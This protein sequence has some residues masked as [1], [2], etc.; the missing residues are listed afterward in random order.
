MVTI[1]AGAFAGGLVSLTMSLLAAPAWAVAGVAI[2]A[3][4]IVWMRPE[5]W[6]LFRNVH[7]GPQSKAADDEGGQ[8]EYRAITPIGKAVGHRR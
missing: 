8:Q 2:L 4:L 7:R 3:V 1:A 5:P 6:T